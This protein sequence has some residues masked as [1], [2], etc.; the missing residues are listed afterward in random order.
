[1][2]IDPFVKVTVEGQSKKTEHLKKNL[3]PTWNTSLDFDLHSHRPEQECVLFEVFDHDRFSS[4]DMI[5][6][7]SVILATLVRGV[8]QRLELKLMNITKSKIVNL[9]SYLTVELLAVDFGL[10]PTQQPTTQQ[11]PVAQQVPVG[12]NPVFG[13][14]PATSITTTT[15]T[16]IVKD[17]GTMEPVTSVT[18]NSDISVQPIQPVQPNEIVHV[19]VGGDDGISHFTVYRGAPVDLP[20]QGWEMKIDINTTTGEVSGSNKNEGHKVKKYYKGTYK[21]GFLDINVEF[22]DGRKLTYKGDLPLQ[23]G[24]EVKLDFKFQDGGNTLTQPED[25]GYNTGKVEMK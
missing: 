13:T 5:G 15:T 21:N 16:Y 17:N 22:D 19:K 20:V 9:D 7:V 25:M 11:Q 6:S 12:G 23:D 8:P 3:N 18:S 4:N 1:M 10:I 14:M 2:A 24:A